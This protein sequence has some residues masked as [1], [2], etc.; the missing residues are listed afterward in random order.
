[1]RADRGAP[2]SGAPTIAETGAD[3]S[4]K[5]PP[6]TIGDRIGAHGSTGSTALAAAGT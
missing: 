6:S 2:A 1:M 5:P 4:A 3:V